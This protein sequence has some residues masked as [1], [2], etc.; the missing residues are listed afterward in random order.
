MKNRSIVHWA[1]VRFVA[2]I[3]PVGWL[4][5]C[6]AAA[7]T[8]VHAQ[9]LSTLYNF[10]SKTNCTDGADPNAGLVL[11]SDG[12]FYGTTYSGGLT[13]CE[14]GC[15]TV[16]KITP[17]ELY[18]SPPVPAGLLTTLYSFC[19]T[20]SGQRDTCTDGA[21]PAAGLT[22][23]TDGNFYGTTQGGGVFSQFGGT[24]FKI[25]SDGG[26]TTLYSF[27]SEGIVTCNDGSNPEGGLVQASNGYFYGTTYAGGLNGSGTVFWVTAGTE[28]T[29]YSFC[30]QSNCTDGGYPEDALVLGS[31]GNFYGTTSGVGNNGNYVN[32][33]VFKITPAGVLTTLYSF[34]SQPNCTDGKSPFAALV[35]ASNGNFYGTTNEGGAN[36]AGTV[37]KITPAGVLTTLYSFCSKTNCTDGEYPD[38]G[39]MQASD[40]N[41]YGTTSN[42]GS[43]RYGTLFEIT[44]A[45]ALTTLYNFCSKTNCTDG[46]IPV[47]GLVQTSN[48]TFYGTTA[49]GG[50]NGRGTIF[51]F[52]GENVPSSPTCNGLFYG[53]YVGDLVVSNGYVCEFTNGGSVSGNINVTGGTLILENAS[54]GGNVQI[55]GGGS[56]SLGPSL[57]IMGNVQIQNLPDGPANVICGATVAGNLQFQNN[58]TAVQIGYP[59]SCT[60]SLIGG[61][62]QVTDNGAATWIYNSTITGDL[63]DQNNTASTALV[64][65]SVGGNLQ[66]QNNTASTQVFNNAVKNDL[67]CQNNTNITGGGNT[68]RLKQGQ[69]TNF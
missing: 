8:R 26:L 61:N 39:L 28:D 59:S 63:Q 16:F 19:G 14:G 50:V 65:N 32:G 44:P 13:S 24:V 12:Y 68:A 62:L 41:F 64:G 17:V 7:P 21:F 55:Q 11:G 52:G 56:F 60:G 51:S 37:F 38:D 48:G 57:K 20:I 15:G 42:G 30:S 45:G 58:A 27:C 31:D 34:C 67:Q 66:A 29:I 69:C 18:T 4:L 54:V 40:G 43:G 53:H 25:T 23:G 46:A 3:C 10:C 35:Q 47:A 5:L 2:A 1:R 33:T 36:G 49:E 9:A 6:M 22:L